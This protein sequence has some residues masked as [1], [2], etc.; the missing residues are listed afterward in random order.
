M[1]KIDI[2]KELNLEDVVDIISLDMKDS[3]TYQKEE[4]GLRCVGPFYIHGRYSTINEVKSFHDVFEFDIFAAKEKLDGEPFVMQCIGYDYSLVNGVKLNLHFDVHGIS[5][6]EDETTSEVEMFDLRENETSTKSQRE[7]HIPTLSELLNDEPSDAIY[8]EPIKELNEVLN[9]GAEPETQ[10]E[11]IVEA[12]EE[13]S[14]KE[15]NPEDEMDLSMMEELFDDKDNVITSYSFVVVKPEDS[16]ESIA[17][18]YEVDPQQLREVNHDKALQ[19]KQLIVLPYGSV[20]SH[21]EE[22]KA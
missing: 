1:K 10:R 22:N 13:E 21:S 14:E 9:D 20:A 16:Y 17:R 2:E 18:R 19:A 11:P 4:D 3:F 15:I 12:V 6:P 5:E 7:L 8:P